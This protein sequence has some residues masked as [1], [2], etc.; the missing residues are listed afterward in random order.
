MRDENLQIDS[1]GDYVYYHHTKY[2]LIIDIEETKSNIS[3]TVSK[4]Y[5]GQLQKTRTISSKKVG[6][7]SLEQKEDYILDAVDKFLGK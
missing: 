5:K 7:M 4:Y 2:P 3:V 6:T 1:S